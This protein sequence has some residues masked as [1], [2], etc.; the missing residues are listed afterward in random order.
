[1][2][3]PVK[4]IQRF[5]NKVEKTDGCWL[6]IGSKSKRGYGYFEIKG[7]TFKSHRVA[8]EISIGKIPRDK[9]V[10]HHCDNPSCVRP[11]H[12]WIGTFEENNHD[13]MRKGRMRSLGVPCKLS[14]EQKEKMRNLYSKRN[15]TLEELATL[16]KVSIGTVHGIVR[17]VMPRYGLLK[18]LK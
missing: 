10:C 17:G 8:Y 5:W 14:P 2:K 6:W 11:E 1:M 7:K 18:S 13:M 9:Y 3:I 12:L 16:F 15:I 4:T